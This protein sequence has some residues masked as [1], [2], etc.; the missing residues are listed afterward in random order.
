MTPQTTLDLRAAR[1]QA[2]FDPAALN[3]LL[4][5]GSPGGGVRG[6]VA[7]LLEHDPAFDKTQRAYAARPEQLELGLRAMKR[8]FEIADRE[9][10]TAE[11]FT[12]ALAATDT[13]M[14]L[15]L[16]EL[17]FTPVIVSQGSD[18][19]HAEWLGKCRNHEILGCYLQTEL[20]HGSNVQQLE[21]TA[22]YDASSDSFILHS[23]TVSATKWWIGS[24]GVLS[25][26]GVVQARLFIK[27][28]D[29]GP[30]LFIF[31]LRS[32]ED[33]SLMP[34]IEAGEIGP[35]VNG[36]M[37][38][39]DNGW[40]RFTHVRIPRKNMLSRFAQVSPDNGG[41]YITPPHSKLSYGSM[42]YIRAQMISNLAWRLAKGVTISTR[43]LFQRRQFADPDLEPGEEGFGLER[44]V[45]TYPSVYMRIVPQVVNTVVFIEAGKDMMDLY[46]TMSAS[47]STGS[48]TRLAE[49]HAVSSA[50]KVYVSTAVV[51]GLE[52]ARRAMGGHG[53]LAATGVGRV[54]AQELP[55]VTYEG[56][57]FILNL[58]VARAALKS[59]RTFLSAPSPSAA[60]S[61]LTP[62]SSYLSALPSLS[63]LPLPLSDLPTTEEGWRSL[64]LL[65]RL[66]ALR[67][68]AS[69]ANLGARLEKDGKKFSEL[70][71]EC[72]GVSE[73]VVEAFLAER[74]GE[75][76]GRGRLGEGGG[77]K[78]KKV[79]EKVV[80]FFLLH[81]LSLALP[82][83]LTLGILPPPP[84]AFSPSSSAS[85]KPPHIDA[86]RAAVDAA[87][88][89]LVP[90][91]V[92][93]TDAFGFSDWELDSVAGRFD[94][95]VYELML[96]KAKADEALNVGSKAQQERLY[97][98]YIRPV[99]QRGKRMGG[100]AKL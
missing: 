41:T 91:L 24:L 12:E 40:A 31:Q 1:T 20:G 37:A 60:L 71:W 10:F 8:L 52:T 89:E 73:A 30:H 65:R 83:L 11:E 97:R 78:E 81:R 7:K 94:G 45:I 17:A 88:K 54:W 48:T 77:E 100:G 95:N 49:T 38:S 18:E 96:A 39:L 43:Y 55:S 47:L 21:T 72:V 16:H 80:V 27:G 58:Q 86:L 62:S 82:S 35:K 5:A 92:G 84:P 93:L 53:F 70:S 69:V 61:A 66:F 68:A 22:T 42:V 56:D 46:R 6:R 23:P 90:E 32:L 99:L 63:S 85:S 79:L 44:Q 33:H 57:N 51:D 98:E 4:L 34:G 36:A 74:L 64:P 15:N 59:L 76:V 9:K 75:K 14:G 29:H 67:A 3:R 25:T 2:S 13:P 87:A 28:K 26:H 19:Q 50:L